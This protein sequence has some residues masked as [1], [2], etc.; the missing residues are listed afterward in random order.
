MEKIIKAAVE[1]GASDLHSKAGDVFRARINGKLVALTKQRLTPDQLV[2]KAGYVVDEMTGNAEFATPI[3]SLAAV[4][5]A[6]QTLVQAIEDAKS[7]SR[8]SIVA[9]NAAAEALRV[10]LSDLA[11]YVNITAEDLNAAVS[12]GFE[13]AKAPSPI[14]VIA[15]ESLTARTS[16]TFGAADLHWT[17][18]DG[19][20]MYKVYI[21]EGE[22]NDAS[23]WNAVADTTRSRFTVTG[24]KR[25]AYYS[26]MVTAVGAHNE[27]AG[28]PTATAKA[29]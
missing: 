26:F 20:R 29:A 6:Q 11:A 5:A 19:S 2:G 13:Q 12:S 7:F 15:P 10:L 25:S 21:T 3:P 17:R 14:K 23:E 4:T 16:D 28:S 18:V 9:K 27:S 1:R 24:L 8:S 22:V